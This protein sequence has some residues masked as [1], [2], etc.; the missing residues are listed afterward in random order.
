M[1]DRAVDWTN[2]VIAILD[3]GGRPC[4]A[5]FVASSDGLIVTCD[6]VLEDAGWPF[7]QWD[8]PVRLKFKAT[9]DW[10]EALVNQ[11]CYLQK[12]EGDIA[13]LT[14][15]GDLPAGVEP[16]PI[17]A[18]KGSED[19]AVRTWGYPAGYANGL[20]GSGKVLGH[21]K[22][23][24][25]ERLQLWSEQT[26]E[27]D[28]GGPVWDPQWGS[29][30][31][32]VLSGREADR[33]GRHRYTWFAI[34][35]ESLVAMCEQLELAKSTR[36][37]ANSV[38]TTVT[39]GGQ[40]Q[41]LR[42]EQYQIALHWDGKTRMREFDLSGLNLSGLKLAGADLAGANLRRTDL[43]RSDLSG[44]DLSELTCSMRICGGPI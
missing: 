1:I 42:D 34:P 43:N 39:I 31:G 16:L 3:R 15:Q 37:S 17:A 21:T 7:K 6:H 10:A 27:G 35:S 28:S 33:R 20:A 12:V 2:G 38:P 26:T 32:M 11:D 4:G 23:G 30:I 41:G 14:L 25:F 5:G 24:D 9:G 8:K 22:L 44:A 36:K 40:R 19:H 18:S 29:V 13:V